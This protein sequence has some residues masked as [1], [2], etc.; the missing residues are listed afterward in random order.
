MQDVLYDILANGMDPE[1]SEVPTQEVERFL[2]EHARS[3]K[4]RDEFRAFF[5]QHGLSLRTNLGPQTV[6]LVLPPI[7]RVAVEDR[8][9]PARVPVELALG[10]TTGMHPLQLGEAALAAA[11]VGRQRRVVLGVWFALLCMTALLAGGGYYGYATILE[12]QGELERTA[13]NGREN[14]QALEALH[15]HAVGMESSVAATGELMQQMDQKSNLLI[16]TLLPDDT[17]TGRKR[18]P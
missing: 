15:D 6:G 5:A 2:F 9:M 8:G 3:P 12:L 16:H 17:K 10:G 1:R 18:K 14:Q 13:Q 11:P 4:S 7:E